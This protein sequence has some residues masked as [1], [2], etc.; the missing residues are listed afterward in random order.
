MKTP[1]YREHLTL[2]AKMTE[3]A[4]WEMPLY[5]SGIV[6]EVKLVRRS[7]GIFDLSHMGQFVVSGPHA[8]DLI[9]W[10]TTNDAA[11]LKQGAA[12][13]T[14]LC[15]ESGGILEDLIVYRLR[16]SLFMLVVNASNLDADSQ[17]MEGHN[18]FGAVLQDRSSETG[19]VAVQGPLAARIMGP[20]VDFDLNALRRFNAAEGRVGDIDGWVARTGYTGEDGFEIYCAAEDAVS[21]WESLLEA[22]RAFDAQPAGLGARD[23][24]RLEAGYPLYGNE[25]TRDVTP[26]DAGL[27]WVVEFAKED[28]VGKEAIQHAAAQGPEQ[29]LVGLE[30]VE[31]CVPRHGYGV[32]ADGERAGFVTSG[33]FSPTLEKGI[34]MA[35]VKPEYADAGALDVEIRGKP[36]PCGIVPMPFYRRAQAGAT[37]VKSVKGVASAS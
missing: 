37:G 6:K 36:C 16:P 10:V 26:V 8:L 33:T 11:R 29:V 13:Y 28:F 27:L 3:F 19:L 31:R 21:L 24:L 23:I 30:A 14:L 20:L 7:A 9:Q 32:F 34:A 18:R 17:W 5:Y 35:Y 15:D 12:Q 4:G 25:L 22:G 1:L 2:G